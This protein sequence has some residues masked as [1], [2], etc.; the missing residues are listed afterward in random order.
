M[1]DERITQ[2]ERENASVLHFILTPLR[3]LISVGKWVVVIGFCLSLLLMNQVGWI[4]DLGDRS[5]R[6]RDARQN[7]LETLVYNNGEVGGQWSVFDVD[8]R[9]QP[10][11]TDKSLDRENRFWDDQ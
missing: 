9:T 3:I 10:D 2:I 6:A 4:V 8:F 7:R 11:P 1:A 5:Q